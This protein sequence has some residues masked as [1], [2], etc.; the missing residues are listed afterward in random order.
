M[1]NTAVIFSGQGSGFVGMGKDINDAFPEAKAVFAEVDDVLGEK[2][3]DIMWGGS[4]EELSFTV[5]AQ[6]ALMA[7]GIAFLRVLQSRCGL[8]FAKHNILFTA[9]HSLGEYTALCAANALTLSD[10]VKLLKA[11]A[12][13]MSNAVK[14]G[15]GGMISLLGV[16]AEQAQEIA[17]KASSSFGDSDCICEVSNDNSVGQVV[18]SGHLKALDKAAEIAKESGVKLVIPLAV[19]GPFHSSLMQ[20]AASELQKALDKAD[21]KSP[22]V[23]VIAN[24]S[25]APV[26]AP[27]DIKKCLYKQITSKVRWRES[28]LFMQEHGVGNLLELGGNG[29]LCKLKKRTAPSLNSAHIGDLAGLDAFMKDFK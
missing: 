11:R 7:T 16:T 6:P 18:L 17:E 5:N 24:V 23:P 15:T 21:F 29:V 8:D 14:S 13:A 3:S 28:V 20:P 19:S 26:Q 9:G 4:E 2:L 22:I 27:A 10:T 12:L 25:A 1:E